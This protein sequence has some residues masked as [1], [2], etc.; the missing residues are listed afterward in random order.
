MNEVYS[1]CCH[2]SVRGKYKDL[3][4]TPK[5]ILRQGVRNPEIMVHSR[6][7]EHFMFQLTWFCFS[8][9]DS[10]S[11]CYS[12]TSLFRY[13][14]YCEHGRVC[15]SESEKYLK[16]AFIGLDNQNYAACNP[17]SCSSLFKEKVNTYLEIVQKKIWHNL[18]GGINKLSYA[19]Q[20]RTFWFFFEDDV[21]LLRFFML[22][23]RARSDHRCL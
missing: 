1:Y 8:Q 19:S 11:S 17:V 18:T 16:Q 10:G 14:V 12:M 2:V 15:V 9:N 5:P 6:I 22:V 23:T 13:C 20:R 3:A 21:S 4:A 7:L